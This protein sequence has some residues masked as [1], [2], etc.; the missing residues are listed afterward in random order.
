[1]VFS[2]EPQSR[3]PHDFRSSIVIEAQ[4]KHIGKFMNAFD[5]G[6]FTKC[7]DWSSP[8]RYAAGKCA[9]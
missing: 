3:R 9:N 1:M 7:C 6:K 4:S 5:S 2:I 8:Q